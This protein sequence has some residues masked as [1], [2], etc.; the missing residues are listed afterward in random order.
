MND[1]QESYENGICPDC[2]EPIP[3]Y[4]ESGEECLNCGHVFFEDRDD[5]DEEIE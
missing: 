3:D 5:D 2:G 1:I 4:I